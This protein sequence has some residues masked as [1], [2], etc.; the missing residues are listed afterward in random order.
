MF[1]F[2]DETSRG[3]RRPKRLRDGYALLMC[4]LVAAVSSLALMGI[5]NTVRFETMECTAK[6]RATAAN[7]AARA[8]IE[9]G[10]AS[11]LVDP[12]LRGPLLP[13]QLPTGS[14]NIVNVEIQQNGQ[15][16][17]VMSTAS[18]AGLSKAQSVTFTTSQLQQRIAAT[19]P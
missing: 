8:G 2:H 1:G 15:N 11:L 10:I 14:S 12:T 4:L 13:I 18:V 7:W 9:Y 17:S 3:S 6:Q 16:L 19:P 5:L